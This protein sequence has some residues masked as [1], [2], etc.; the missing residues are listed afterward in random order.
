MLLKGYKKDGFENIKNYFLK[1][2]PSG[3]ENVKAPAPEY[4]DQLP[5]HPHFWEES[6]L[7][8]IESNELPGL[9]EY[10]GDAAQ[11]VDGFAVLVP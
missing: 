3:T 9:I 2:I 11:T 10:P 5:R 1:L 4:C 8:A 7:Q 6:P